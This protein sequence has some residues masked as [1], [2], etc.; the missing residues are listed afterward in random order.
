MKWWHL[1]ANVKKA[2]FETFFSIWQKHLLEGSKYWVQLSYCWSWSSFLFCLHQLNIIAAMSAQ[3]ILSIIQK[4]KRSKSE[5]FTLKFHGRFM[6]TIMSLIF[7]IIFFRERLYGLI[8]C[9][10]PKYISP[11]EFN[12]FCASGHVFKRMRDKTYLKKTPLEKSQD[13]G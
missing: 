11:N 12:S 6:L 2:F 13:F 7:T 10:P 3:E 1:W 8:N 5:N 9:S 4:K